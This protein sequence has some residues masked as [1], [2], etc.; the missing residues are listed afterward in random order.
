M[1]PS[2]GL[3]VGRLPWLVVTSLVFCSSLFLCSCSESPAPPVPRL[4]AGITDSAPSDTGR[5]D[6]PRP[7]APV[8]PPADVEVVLPFEG[9][10]QVIDRTIVALP[11]LMDVHFSVDT[12]GSFGEE[13]DALQR[14]LEESIVPSL[15]RRV[16]DI[17]FGVSRFEDFPE[18]PYGGPEDA[19]FALLAGITTSRERIGGGV[20]RLDQPFGQGGDV[21]ESG[22]EAL[23]Q[24]ATGAGYSVG[25][26][27]YIP[28]FDRRRAAA[29]GPLG[30]VGFRERALHVVVHVTDAP[31]HQPRDY[32]PQFPDTRGSRDAIAALNA[33][34]AHVLGIASNEAARPH[35]EALALATGAVR[36]NETG[37]ADET[38]PTG[39]DGSPRPSSGGQCPLVFD[40]G[41]DGSGLSTAVV[42]AIIALLDSV[43]YNEAYGE[44]TDDPLEFVQAIEA[45]DAQVDDERLAPMRA[46]LRPMDGIDDTFVAVRQA[47][48]LHFGIRLQNLSIR[49]ADY[50]Q[51][52]RIRVQILG[53]GTV[54]DEV[55]IRVVV[56]P[57]ARA[58][59]GEPQ[60]AAA[61][62]DASVI[63]DGASST[64][65]LISVDGDV[66][67]EPMD[68]RPDQDARVLDGSADDGSNSDADNDTADAQPLDSAPSDAP[69]DAAV[70]DAG[71]EDADA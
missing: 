28:R 71:P 35:L 52:F 55:T 3:P 36:L 9:P 20:A 24:I 21:A 23:Y 61:G 12:T 48:E 25:G 56:P 54:L 58:D 70:Q 60:D 17:A 19:P 46:D 53:D 40:I 62:L 66:D 50:D 42:D 31:P 34:G 44:T 51:T 68:A 13:I 27:T 22:Y 64:D 7:D 39:I 29:L 2:G 49:S 4:D 11:G 8:L 65:G 5:A 26:V 33:I 32:L 16:D 18:P 10:T 63:T 57:L 47:T 45:L 67:A 41:A 14:S 30:G 38:C 59:A 69:L 37:S 1:S 15:Q 43:R 6:R